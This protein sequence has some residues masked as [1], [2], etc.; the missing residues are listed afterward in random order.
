MFLIKAGAAAAGVVTVFLGLE[1]F[2]SHSE[3]QVVCNT[4]QG[5]WMQIVRDPRTLRAP[6]AAAAVALVGARVQAACGELPPDW[7]RA[8]EN[9]RR[10][11]GLPEIREKALAANKRAIEQL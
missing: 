1:V 11:V 7:D 2:L 8:P 4:Q 10:L 6:D 3:T 9:V 5:R